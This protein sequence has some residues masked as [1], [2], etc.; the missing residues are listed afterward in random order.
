VDAPPGGAEHRFL[1]ITADNF[2]DYL[3][4]AWLKGT[5][6]YCSPNVVAPRDFGRYLGRVDEGGHYFRWTMT[7]SR[8]EV[9][10]SIRA[11]VPEAEKFERLQDLRV[12]ARGVSGRALKMVLEYV[13]SAGAHQE[14]TLPSEYRIRQAL[15]PGFLFSSAIAI[16]IERDSAGTPRT[17]T[18]RGAGWGHGAGLCQIGALGMGLCGIDHAAILKHYFPSTKLATVYP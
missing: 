11:H 12:T 14:F 7:L 5:K 6:A 4:G 10:Q 8:A 2:Q 18:Y 3:S 13:N 16:E 1:P 9:E 15:H 17:I